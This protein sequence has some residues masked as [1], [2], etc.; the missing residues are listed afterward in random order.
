M[1]SAER[2][3]AIFTAISPPDADYNRRLVAVLRICGYELGEP[4]AGTAIGEHVW[5]PKPW[6][7]GWQ[8][9]YPSTIV[10]VTPQLAPIH[11]R[12]SEILQ[13]RAQR[14][15]PPTAPSSKKAISFNTLNPPAP[16]PRRIGA[17]PLP[18]DAP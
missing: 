12:A 17:W 9:P 16:D 6:I 7:E 13:E 5:M 1:I 8:F 10:P 18:G 4:P 11:P 14:V 2:L 3:N 15:V